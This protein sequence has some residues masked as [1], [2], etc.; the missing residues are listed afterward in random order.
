MSQ[1]ESDDPVDTWWSRL[2]VWEKKYEKTEKIDKCDFFFSC[3]EWKMKKEPP[4]QVAINQLFS[5]K[6]KDIC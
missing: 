3:T 1:S 5:L 6:S 4:S 2:Y